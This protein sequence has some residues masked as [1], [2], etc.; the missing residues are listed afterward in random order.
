MPEVTETRAVVRAFDGDDVL[1]EAAQGGCGRC[2]EEGGC[3]GQNLTQMF[4]S[5]PKVWRLP[6]PG[7]LSVGDAVMVGIAA[8]EVR[9]SANVA[10]GLPL[11]GILLG[12]VSGNAVA[13]DQGAMLGAVLGFFV[14][15]LLARLV[16]RRSRGQQT[17]ITLRSLHG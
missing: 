3:G 10:Y 14:A 11:L 2:H 16:S 15:G 9:H 5:A 1:I 7:G 4:C 13:S 6:N 12:A 8:G 17:C